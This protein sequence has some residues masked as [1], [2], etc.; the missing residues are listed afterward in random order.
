[1]KARQ[2]VLYVILCGSNAYSIDYTELF[3]TPLE[4]FPTQATSHNIQNSPTPCSTTSSLKAGSSDCAIIIEPHWEDLEKTK[5][6][7]EQ[8]G[9]KWILAGTI[10]FKKKCNSHENLEELTLQ[11]HGSHLD[12]LQ[13][14]LFIVKNP[15]TF[16]PINENHV[17]DGK[18]SKERQVLELSFNRP[19]SLQSS[20][21]LNLVLTIPESQEPLLK[22]H[23]T[24]A[25]QCLPVPFQ[26][27]ASKDPLSINI[28][29]MKCTIH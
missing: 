6:R 12:N 16:K 15:G 29:V 14:S 13:G 25:P 18:W 11:W 22:G 26:E 27:A 10:T 20:T 8:F 28:D 2:F 19:L 23:F 17:A 5:D 7:S 3:A 9:G 4:P 24:I 1:M 21:I